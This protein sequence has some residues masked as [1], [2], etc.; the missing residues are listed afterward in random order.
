MPRRVYENQAAMQPASAASGLGD[1]FEYRIKEPVTLRQNESALVPIVNTPVAAEKI[2]LWNRGASTGRPLRAVWL[3]NSSDLT[4]DGGSLTVI[5]ANA[6]AGEGLIEPLK[7]GEKRL[8]SYAAELGVLVS[9]KQEPSP[10][11]V[12]RV[13]ARD[14][15][16][17]HQNEERSTSTYTARNE[18]AAPVTLIV[19]HRRRPDWQLADG[20][21]PAE[22]TADS[23]RFRVVVD[24]GKEQVVTVREVHAGEN[25]VLISELADTYVAEGMRTN[26]FSGDVRK[27]LEPVLEKRAEIAGLDRQVTALQAQLDAIV[28]DQSR[29]RENM[30]ALRGS[31]EERQLLQRYTRQLDEQ[32]TR[33]ERLRGEIAQATARRDKAREEMS[34]LIAAMSFDI[35]VGVQP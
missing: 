13:R 12:S 27:A 8:V 7:P 18:N 31:E 25:R 15:I 29:L 32:E 23:Y 9:G 28:Q 30:K 2:A 35:Q 24:A 19:E 22:T 14:G 4:L 17:I 33:L 16:I 3:T 26:M 6:F 21:T 34:A 11:R 20:V 10:V 5:D 1:L